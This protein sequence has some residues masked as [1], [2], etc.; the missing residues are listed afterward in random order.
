M[1][2]EPAIRRKRSSLPS[3]TGVRFFAALLVFFI[4]AL[5]PIGPVDHTGPVNP[6]GDKDIAD[7]L[8]KFFG[9]AGFLGVSFFFLLSGFVI[10]WSVK[11]GEKLTSY[12][13]RRIVKIF[14]NHLVTWVLALTLF[15]YAYT[16]KT[17]GFL[18]LI[19]VNSWVNKLDVQMSVNA[20]SWSLC[21]ELLFYLCF[22]L[23]LLLVRKIPVNRLY[24]WAGAMV[25]AMV[26]VGLVTVNYITNS[27]SN[28]MIPLSPS[29]MWFNYTF[30]PT[31]MFEFVLGMLVARIVLA[32]KWP[33]I[34][35]VP[36]IALAAI[37]YVAAIYVP[38]PYNFV[39]TTAIPF[40]VVIASLATADERG[41]KTRLNG[42]VM[43]WLGNVSFGFYL[44]QGIVIFWGRQALLG[45]DQFS[46]PVAILVM[47]GM[48]LATLL[49]GWLLY[50]FVEMPAMRL[51]SR[52]KK[53]RAAAAIRIDEAD[54]LGTLPEQR[55][56]DR[57]DAKPVVRP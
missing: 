55:T 21:V 5:Q 1:D 31:R 49:A 17:T 54:D 35:A 50:T 22:P 6:F 36:V 25:V 15:A 4:H 20:P 11:P 45:N 41:A 12:W 37:G 38:A 32:G 2:S 16:S 52:S 53:D 19:L 28:P 27:P 23:L 24:L 44:A 33:K 30:P 18:S 13:R 9:P 43:V 46:T 29:Q 39:A 3:L 10:T 34:G 56:G 26:G 7:G 57:A 42:K 51:W 40:S 14:P 47:I 48:F 8:Y